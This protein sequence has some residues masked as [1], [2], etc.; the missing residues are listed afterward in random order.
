LNKA[1]GITRDY[2]S[3]RF[4]N[5]VIGFARRSPSL[6]AV[7][8]EYLTGT[9]SYRVARKKLQARSWAILWEAIRPRRGLGREVEEGVRKNAP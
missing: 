6:S 4:L 3:K 7:L 2:F 1:Y 8:G 9:A 5:L